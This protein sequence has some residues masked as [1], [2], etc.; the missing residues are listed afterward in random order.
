MIK[1]KT[2]GLCIL[3]M[4]VYVIVTF[5]MDDSIRW[6]FPTICLF[7]SIVIMG[8]IISAIFFFRKP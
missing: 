3:F 6:S 2:Y 1:T 8:L 5:L 7:G 4:T